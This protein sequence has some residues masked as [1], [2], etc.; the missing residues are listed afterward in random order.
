MPRKITNKLIDFAES[1][2]LPWE[3]LAREC[4]EYMSEDE[5]AD[6]A[7]YNG[8]DVFDEPDDEE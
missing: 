3:M 1:G 5:V 8:H 6:M 2:I 4:L 7:N